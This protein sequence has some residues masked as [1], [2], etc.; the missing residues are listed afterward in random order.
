MR[1]VRS[2][3]KAQ[4]R[5]P[6][7]QYGYRDLTGPVSGVC[8]LLAPPECETLT[9]VIV[10]GHNMQEGALSRRQECAALALYERSAESIKARGCPH[11]TAPRW[12]QRSGNPAGVREIG[13]MVT[14]NLCS[15]PPS[16][17]SRTGTGPGSA[18]CPCPKST[19][20]RY[21]R[22]TVV[23]PC[24]CDAVSVGVYADAGNTN[25]MPWAPRQRCCGRFW[26]SRPGTG[27]RSWPGLRRGTSSSA[28]HPCRTQTRSIPACS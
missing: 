11:D 1:D 24:R 10:C 4:R 17:V 19:D 25:G 9:P 2:T 3:G 28:R 18:P 8:S 22:S 15:N 16:A 6:E 14:M 12:Q 13:T 26:I 7:L 20:G 23:R 21:R 5:A 27:C